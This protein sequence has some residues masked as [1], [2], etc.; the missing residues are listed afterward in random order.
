VSTSDS[1]AKRR[2]FRLRG[3]P[4]GVK[5]SAVVKAGAKSIGSSPISDIVVPVFGVSKKHAILEIVDGELFVEDAGSKNGVF[6]N[7]VRAQRAALK[8]GDWVQLG[9]AALRVEEITASDADIAIAIDQGSPGIKQV[10]PGDRTA[11][12]DFHRPR[13]RERWMPLLSRI[14]GALLGQSEPAMSEILADL[15]EGLGAE[16]VSLLEWTGDRSPVALATWGR[17][18]DLDAKTGLPPALAELVRARRATAAVVSATHDGPPPLAWAAASA[19]GIPP[20]A[21]VVQGEFPHREAAGPLLEVVLRMALRAQPQRLHFPVEAEPVELPELSFPAGYVPGRSRAILGVYEQLGMLLRGDIPLLITGETG[22]GKEHIARILHASSPRARGP[23]VAVNCA[24]IPSELLEAELFGIEEGVATGVRK[25]DGTFQHAAGGVIL[26]DEIGDTPLAVQAKLLRALQANEVHPVGARLPQ[27]ID[28]RVLAATNTD[29]HARIESGQFRRDLY[30]RIAGYTLPVPALRDRRQ[31]IPLLVEHFMRR[32]AIEA[33][34]RIQGIT[35]HAL[36]ALQNAPWPGNIRE[37]E[38]EVRR[39]V[40][41]CPEGQAI[42]AG[43]LS[44]DLLY[45]VSNKAD[46]GILG[47]D[48]NLAREVEAVER[49]MIILALARF[50]NSSTKAAAALGISRA[51][52]AMKIRRLRIER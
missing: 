10:T 33:G 9:P 24:A 35:V 8:P 36:R 7:G 37:L 30:Y 46:H 41:L 27:R 25:R 49:R 5:I 20:R 51:G 3:E 48:L 45:S 16:G 31:D 18:A 28:V 42:D 2:A 12:W 38:H 34:K 11:D 44:P 6:V 52:L 15:G 17:L 50:K 47:R 14:S 13:A 40:Y 23:F 4:E 22:V 32:S 26:L 1:V 43:C 29:L 21:L 39:L 19:R